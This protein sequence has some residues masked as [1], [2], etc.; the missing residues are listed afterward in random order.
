[1][2]R[3]K[4]KKRK[5]A[6]LASNRRLPTFNNFD[7]ELDRMVGL[8]DLSQQFSP[9]QFGIW[10]DGKYNYW[11]PSFQVGGQ[12]IPEPT[13]SVPLSKALWQPQD[14]NTVSPAAKPKAE[15][16]ETCVARSQ[17]TEVIHAT[18]RAGKRGQKSPLW[19]EKS[20]I[21]C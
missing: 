13:K 1:M 11:Q 14:V 15:P 3:S 10:S 21:K 18:G 9:D 20:K 4:S 8:P 2:G 7:R 6:K 5:A 17:R 16:I 12:P 19:T